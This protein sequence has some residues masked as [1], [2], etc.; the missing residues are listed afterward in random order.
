MAEA[1]VI[2]NV[3]KPLGRVK[4]LRG[5]NCG[6]LSP[7]GWDVTRSLNLTHY[8][9]EL[10]IEVIRFHDLHMAD[11]LDVIFPDPDADP[12]SPTSY[13][14][15]ELDR[16]VE[17]AQRVAEI[18]IIRIGFDWHD[19][20]RNKPH[21]SL[22]KLASIVEHVVLHYMKGWA[23]G[24]CYRNI[25]WEVWNEPDIGRFWALSAQEYFKLYEALARAVK[26][27]DLR[28]MVEGP[29]IAYN[30]TF[31]KEFLNYIRSR[32][33]PLD[34][35]SW[36]AYSTDPRDI[37]RRAERVREIM[38]KYGYEELPSVLDEW[39][40]WWNKEPWD[41][42]RGPVVAA[43]QTST[44]TWLQDAPVDIVTLYRG[45]RVV[46]FKQLVERTTRVEARVM[47]CE[48]AVAAGLT[49]NGSLY[50][51]VSNH[52][53]LT[54]HYR[55]E[56]DEEFR[57]AKVLVVDADHDL[58]PVDACDSGLTCSIGPYAVQLLELGRLSGS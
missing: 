16:N 24:Y 8:Y 23:D 25:L 27:A 46:A 47:G 30:L 3:S 48:I 4:D 29:T 56:L 10:G 53:D 12:N 42:F 49:P 33:V 18:I 6:P 54:V 34:F 37:V 40:Y 19:P 14:F 51:L 57:V 39:N 55:L 7:R 52:E 50:I 32:G 31:L 17:A 2:V 13:N 35:V 21:V 43:F 44:L 28:A 26:R 22:D 38:A 20:P 11:D 41:F 5:V 1:R 36:H 58:S 45:G 15:S 9:V